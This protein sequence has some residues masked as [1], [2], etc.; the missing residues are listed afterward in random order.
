MKNSA[1]NISPLAIFPLPAIFSGDISIN[2]GSVLK[3]H[4]HR[5]SEVVPLKKALLSLDGI[6]IDSMNL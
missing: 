6:T 2:S 4:A 5:G 1:R 3:T